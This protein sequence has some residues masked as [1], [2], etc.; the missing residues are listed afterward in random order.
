MLMEYLI[1]GLWFIIA[2]TALIVEL[3]TTE[4]VSVWFV[5]GAFITM[6]VAAIWPKEYVAQGCTFVIASAI[7]LM[8]LRPL[9]AKR[10]K[11][12]QETVVD[13]INSLE[14]YK[15]FAE[16]D[17]DSYGGKANVN[18]TSWNAV[19]SELIKEG[20]RIEVIKEDNIT[21]TVKKESREE[22]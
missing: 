20:D 3:Q 13:K 21:L 7:S 17:I 5:V 8:I 16:T 10:L 6:I 4:L 19:S 18:G 14:G 15:G 9:L 2:I 1:L 12:N 22:N 11:I